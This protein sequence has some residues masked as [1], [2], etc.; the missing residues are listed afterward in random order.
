MEKVSFKDIPIGTYFTYITDRGTHNYYFKTEE[1]ETQD[2]KGV[3]GI[4]AVHIQ[5]QRAGELGGFDDDTQVYV[6]IV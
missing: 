6:G 5:G 4:N 2:S 3:Y 1:V